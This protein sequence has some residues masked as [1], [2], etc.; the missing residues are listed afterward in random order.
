M[1]LLGS[2]DKFAA[3]SLCPGRFAVSS[4]KRPMETFKRLSAQ[5]TTAR[6]SYLK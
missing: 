5:G 1:Y 3:C 4:V 2:S 6:G